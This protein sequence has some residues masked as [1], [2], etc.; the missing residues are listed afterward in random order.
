MAVGGG[1]EKCAAMRRRHAIEPC[2]NIGDMRSIECCD[3]LASRGWGGPEGYV[4]T[5]VKSENQ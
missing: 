4:L 1:G 2:T 5:D 3:L